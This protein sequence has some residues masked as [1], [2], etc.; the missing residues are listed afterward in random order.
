MSTSSNLHQFIH[1]IL[2]LSLHFQF[3]LHAF[4]ELLRLGPGRY[5]QQNYWDNGSRF[6]T[7]TES[8]SYN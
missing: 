4:L 7:P 5:T 8:N 6:L 3:S 1:N 2:L